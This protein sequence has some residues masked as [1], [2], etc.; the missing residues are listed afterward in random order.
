M[1]TTPIQKVEYLSC[2]EVKSLGKG[3]LLFHEVRH[4]IDSC[5]D[6]MNCLICLNCLH[7]LH[8][9]HFPC[10]QNFHQKTCFRLLHLLLFLSVHHTE[11]NKYTHSRTHL[12]KFNKH[13]QE[14]LPIRIL[15]MQSTSSLRRDFM[16]LITADVNSFM[17][18]TKIERSF[19][20]E[21]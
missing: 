17:E 11:R 18:R 14:H 9:F 15:E 19:N 1:C 8:S 16:N 13:R 4:V 5:Q 6:R 20:N 7:F 2:F 21:D 10:R 3:Y 12:N